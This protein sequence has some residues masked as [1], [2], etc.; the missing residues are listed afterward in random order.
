MIR[1]D[2]LITEQPIGEQITARCK[3][4]GVSVSELCRRANV[5]H[6]QVSQWK[7]HDPAGIA[8]LRRLEAELVKLESVATQE[9]QK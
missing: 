1:N 7:K 8:P 5:R 9:V 6:Y 3:S 2:F 4:L